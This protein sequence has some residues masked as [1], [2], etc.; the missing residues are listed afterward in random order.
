[1]IREALNRESENGRGSTR[2]T[3]NPFGWIN[4][5]SKWTCRLRLWNRKKPELKENDGNAQFSLCCYTSTKCRMT[6]PRWHPAFSF[7][8]IEPRITRMRSMRWTEGNQG[9]QGCRSRESPFVFL[10]IFCSE[11]FPGGAWSASP[12]RT[13]GVGEAVSGSRTLRIVS[14]SCR[15]LQASSLCYPIAVPPRGDSGQP[16]RRGTC[17][18]LLSP[19]LFRKAWKRR[20]FRNE[21]QIGSWSKRSQQYTGCRGKSKN[22]WLSRSHFGASEPE[23]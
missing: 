1:V 12:A 11:S 21:S 19:Y 16:R 3:A 18:Q 4:W 20:S 8:G 9:N 10:V 22:L 17:L 15:H 5:S 6:T 2:S 13:S 23:G 14:A 7:C